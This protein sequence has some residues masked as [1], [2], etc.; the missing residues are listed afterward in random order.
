MAVIF[1][2]SSLSGSSVPEGPPALGHFMLYA[3]LGALY[4]LAL[5]GGT[6]AWRV[7]LAIGLASVYGVSDEFHQSFV[8]GRTPDVM[9]W[10]VDTAGAMLAVLVVRA[11]ISRSRFAPQ[12]RARRRADGP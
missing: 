6:R 2:M 10:L 1:G 3:V 11:G 4:Y 5:P 9:D 7:V 12:P 8:P